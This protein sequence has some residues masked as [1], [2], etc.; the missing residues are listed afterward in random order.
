MQ[1]KITNKIIYKLLFF[2][3]ILYLFFPTNNSSLDAYN[4]AASI[5]YGVDLFE[6]HHLF[7]NGFLFLFSKVFSYVSNQ[8]DELSLTKVVNSLFA[9]IN[10]V[11]FLKIL[12]TLK[13]RKKE[14]CT[15]IIIAA[16]SYS[17]LRYGTENETYIIPISFSLLGSYYFLNY[18]IS[19]KQLYILLSGF[20]GSLACLFHQI[21]FFWWLGLLMGVI[22]YKKQFKIIFLY[23]L[24]TLII[25]IAYLLVLYYY[26]YQ[27][28]NIN[29]IWQF[30]FHD[31][32]SGSAKS[33]LSIMNLIFIV[34]SSIRTFFEIHPKIIILIKYNWLFIVPLIALVVLLYKVSRELIYRH[35][36]SKRKNL[37]IKFANTHLLIFA[38]HMAFSFYAVG[39]VE[40]LVMI[41]FLILLS[42]FYIIEVNYEVLIWLSITLFIWNFS[43]G[44]YPNNKF[45]YYNDDVLV[46]FIEEHSD[47]IFVVKE[48]SV[49]TEH[50]YKTGIMPNK[51]IIHFLKIKDL[52]TILKLSNQSFFY[53][54]II[55]KPEILNRAKLLEKENIN[56]SHLKK[57]KIK[58]Y[59]GFYGIS[60][61]YKVFWIVD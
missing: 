28:I 39:N 46:K 9:I 60:T 59:K 41:P 50:Y 2:I 58:E 24:P 30:V 55:D 35:L 43:F 18:L 61:I 57:V 5:K 44:L 37:N 26:N 22:L 52:D 14:I 17:S 23:V 54:D 51:K 4:Y 32:F 21:H 31:Y 11:I 36:F 33:E 15:A 10:L 7:Y 53:T 6:P 48:Q 40:F 38:L 29:N 34:I 25:P 19:E 20:F 49:L 47:N 45:K 42:V 1:L 3:A 56:F 16:F 13:I 27:D 8:I 12:K